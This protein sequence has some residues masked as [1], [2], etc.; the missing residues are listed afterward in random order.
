[1]FAGKAL[2]QSRGYLKDAPL[3][4]ASA[5]DKHQLA[6]VNLGRVFNSR[7]GRVHAIHPWTYWA[8]LFN[9]KLKTR[10]K[11]LLVSLQL[12]PYLQTLYSVVKGC[13]GQT[14]NLIG[15]HHPLDGVTN[16]ENKLCFIQLAIFCKEKKA[17][18]FNRD[19]CCHLALCLR[20]I[21]FH[22]LGSSWTNWKHFYDLDNSWNGRR[23]NC[24]KA[25]SCSGITTSAGG[26]TSW[27][28][29]SCF[30]CS[31]SGG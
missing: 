12:R 7:S 4:Q 11:Q 6:G 9:L 3:G 22:L 20:L 5:R 31:T 26:S 28:S 8:K 10:P 2:N 19:S 25:C 27:R 24:A 14:L 21:L 23:W 16:P 29:P 1:M 17:L 13:Q 18:A 15:L 30:T